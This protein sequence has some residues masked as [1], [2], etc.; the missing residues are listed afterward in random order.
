ML[1][2]KITNRFLAT[3]RFLHLIGQRDSDEC[4][5]CKIGSESLVHLF[6]ECRIVKGFVKNAVAWFRNVRMENERSNFSS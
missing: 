5:F 6:W 2:C 3:N 1:H 4:G